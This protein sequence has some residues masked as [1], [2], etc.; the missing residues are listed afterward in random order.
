M[1][2]TAPEDT[3][4]GSSVTFL[5]FGKKGS[6]LSLSGAT[7]AFSAALEGR[8]SRGRSPVWLM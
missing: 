1:Q 8:A 7:W 4:L 3:C 5:V 6:H 2:R